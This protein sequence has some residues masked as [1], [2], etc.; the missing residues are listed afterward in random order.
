[1]H[2]K[3]GRSPS[4]AITDA[5]R[6]R[7]QKIICIPHRLQRLSTFLSKTFKGRAAPSKN[8]P[9]ALWTAAAKLPLSA[10]DSCGPQTRGKSGSFAAA[11]QSASRIFMDRA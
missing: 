9:K 10:L 7:L 3:A 5:R 11:L 8:V 4:D 2:R 1:M 6:A